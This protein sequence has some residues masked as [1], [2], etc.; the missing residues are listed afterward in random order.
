MGVGYFDGVRIYPP[1]SY[2]VVVV[3]LMNVPFS[4]CC[5][6]V[7]AAQCILPL[8]EQ[9]GLSIPF[10]EEMLCYWSISFCCV[11]PGLLPGVYFLSA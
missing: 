4:I 6:Y 11:L 1:F 2:L 9:R 5:N 7:K 10:F 3:S 8:L